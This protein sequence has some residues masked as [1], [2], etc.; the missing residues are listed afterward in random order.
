MVVSGTV[1]APHVT[2]AYGRLIQAKQAGRVV[3]K[4]EM[5]IELTQMLINYQRKPI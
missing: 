3:G 5:T 4:S 2:R 1:V